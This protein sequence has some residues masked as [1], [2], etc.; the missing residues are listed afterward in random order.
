M[1]GS[2]WDRG[3]GL[4][5]MQMQQQMQSQKQRAAIA[6][7][8]LTKCLAMAD[9]IAQLLINSGRAQ[10]GPTCSGHP[11]LGS[12]CSGHPHLGSTCLDLHRTLA[13][14]NLM[15]TPGPHMTLTKPFVLFMTPI[16]WGPLTLAQNE[17]WGPGPLCQ[18]GRGAK[19][20]RRR[21]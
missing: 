8:I 21:I 12:T 13:S 18:R 3:S 4:G 6:R 15:V 10:L 7:D 16:P 2:L 19:I 20:I 5:L 1:C 9:A 11:Q 17:Y 14:D